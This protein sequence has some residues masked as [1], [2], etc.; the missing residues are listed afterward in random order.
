MVFNMLIKAGN[1]PLQPVTA[2]ANGRYNRAGVF[3]IVVL[4]HIGVGYI[5]SQQKMQ[6]PPPVKQT[7]IS[8]KILH[9][10]KPKP[11]VT[12]PKPAIAAKLPKLTP[13]P[14]QPAKAVPVQ[15]PT[16]QPM[17]KPIQPKTVEQPVTP[18]R[19]VPFSRVQEAP[20]STAPQPATNSTAVANSITPATEPT[21]PAAPAQATSGMQNQ[22]ASTDARSGC[23]APVYPQESEIN[24]EE[25]TTTLAL[26]IAADGKVLQAN[27]ERS[28]GFAGLDRAA[29]KAL[30]LCTFQ[31][32][33]RNGQPEQ[34]WAKLSWKWQLQA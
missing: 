4:L 10:P 21:K 14:V 6:A 30:V 29:K 11:K 7:P 19:E 23:A 22:A 2:P 26:L 1:L 32:A 28:S 34:G 33:I 17:P 25:G 8:V 5:I 3:A 27:I 12:P 16:T 31:P 20:L 15:Q 18:T 13:K 9:L 24:G